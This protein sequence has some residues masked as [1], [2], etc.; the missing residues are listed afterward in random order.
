MFPGNRAMASIEYG[1]LSADSM[2]GHC[3]RFSAC[4]RFTLQVTAQWTSTMFPLVSVSQ[5]FLKMT[6]GWQKISATSWKMYR[7]A[8]FFFFFP[9]NSLECY[10]SFR[11][12]PASCHQF[13]AG[14]ARSSAVLTSLQVVTAVEVGVQNTIFFS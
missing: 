10:K 12:E 3:M 2:G 11:C 5:R 6:D 4:R 14:R 13:N 9:D 7:P 1:I 8:I